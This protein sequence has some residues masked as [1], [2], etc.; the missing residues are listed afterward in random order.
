MLYSYGVTV[1]SKSNFLK[2]GS[3]NGLVVNAVVIVIRHL[4]AGN[5]LTS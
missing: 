5:V 1:Y 3:R 2:I 4:K